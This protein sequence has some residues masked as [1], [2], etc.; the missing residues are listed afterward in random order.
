MYRVISPAFGGVLKTF[1]K[2]DLLQTVGQ[3]TQHY[4]HKIDHQ[5]FRSNKR[6]LIIATD[7]QKLSYRDVQKLD[8]LAKQGNAKVI[9]LNN[10]AS[11]Q[12]FS[13]GNAIKILKETDVAQ[14]VSSAKIP[15]TLIEVAESAQGKRDLAQHYISLKHKE[16]VPVVVFSNKAQSETIQEIRSTLQQQ[17]QLSLQEIHYNTLSSKGLSE[18]EKTKAHCYH[19]GDQITFNP[20]S[21]DYKSFLVT[22]IDKCNQTLSLISVQGKQRT[23]T[24][25]LS[26]DTESFTVKKSQSL[27]IVVGETLRATRNIYIEHQAHQWQ[28]NITF[29]I[30]KNSTF[31]VDRID[32]HGITINYHDQPLLLT[33]E[34]LKHSFIDHG[35]VIKPHQLEKDCEHALTVLSGYQVNQNNMGEI[36]EFAKKVT[37]FTD[38]PEKSIKALHQQNIAWTATDVAT[39][40]VN[41]AYAPIVRTEKAIRNDLTEVAKALCPDTA[42][43]ANQV[44]SAVAYGMAKVAEHEAGFSRNDILQAAMHYAIGQV[45]STDIEKVI[46]DKEQQGLILVG[47]TAVT[48]PYVYQLEKDI[49]ANIIEGHNQITPVFEVSPDLENHLTQGQKDAITLA[50]TTQD[51]FIGI[52]GGRRFG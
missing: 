2:H 13:A 51:R 40:R 22:G 33:K 37:L 30:D 28:N 26:P 1:L 17:R 21:K 18:V 32:Q 48:T 27:A 14:F 4:Q 43:R 35:Y 24:L 25:T 47:N 12:G 39:N 8:D 5:F 52:N 11:T 16:A 45:S 6:D 3:F 15:D 10:M 19:L 38:N 42:D 23:L 44:E 29:K 7:A 36:A 9:F 41:Q 31:I 20:N 49:I 46:K 50:L 34:K